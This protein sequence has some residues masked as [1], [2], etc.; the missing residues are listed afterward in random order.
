ME[1]SQHK[2]LKFHYEGYNNC[3]SHCWVDIFF[4]QK[5]NQHGH[6]T[7]VL[8]SAAQD[9]PG[10]SITNMSEYIATAICGTYDLDVTSTM[11]VE[12]YPYYGELLSYDAI[13]YKYDVNENRFYSPEWKN[14][15]KFDE[16]IVDFIE[17]NKAE[18]PLERAE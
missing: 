13:F 16:E 7:I 3:Q 17:E 9:N 4:L 11:F 6:D 12:C 10:T 18:Y 14:L 2:H 5:R 1:L 8:F 15:N